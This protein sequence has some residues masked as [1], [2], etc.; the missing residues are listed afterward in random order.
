MAP[1]LTDENGSPRPFL[2][3]NASTIRN[4]E[5]F[6]E[7][8]FFNFIL[9]R[10]ITIFFDEAHN[11]PKDLTQ[12][13]LTI[14]NTDSN[15]VRDVSFN[16]QNFTFDFTKVTFLFATT[17]PDK[18]F[19]PLKDRME[20]VEFKPYTEEN[21]GDI[22]ESRIPDLVLKDSVRSEVVST[23]R[24][25]P[26]SAVKRA[27]QIDTYC[28]AYGKAV[29][30]SEDFTDLC[31]RV[32]IQPHGISNMELRVLE[33]LEERGESSLQSLC[34]TSGMSRNALQRDV[35][36]FLLKHGF[37]EINSK[38]SRRQITVK[39]KKVVEMIG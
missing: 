32:D 30:R 24:D 16:N 22:M 6:F 26:R 12:T 18:I 21:L 37:L 3:L 20:P 1:H 4:N 38:N 35:E 33:I 27:T 36:N 11:L 28:Q 19:G 17:E 29:F 14:C 39:G 9:G 23:I 7:H 8:I 34:A 5:A 2:E 10:E 31:K 13:F 25:N 15:P